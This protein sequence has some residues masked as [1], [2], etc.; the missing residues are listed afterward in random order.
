M[1]CEQAGSSR[2]GDGVGGWRARSESV[3]RTKPQI[4][5][6]SLTLRRGVGGVSVPSN[7]A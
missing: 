2:L 4:F 5:L 1:L 6:D 3:P 7:S